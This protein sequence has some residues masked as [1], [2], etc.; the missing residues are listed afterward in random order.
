MTRLWNHFSHFREMS[1]TRIVL[2]Q[3]SK[4]YWPIVSSLSDPFF[5]LNVIVVVVL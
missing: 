2:L 3:G 4:L 5:I 1:F